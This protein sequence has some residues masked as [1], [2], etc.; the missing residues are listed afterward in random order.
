MPSLWKELNMEDTETLLFSGKD[1]QSKGSS[2]IF[3]SLKK[4]PDLAP[5]VNKLCEFMDKSTIDDLTPL[6]DAVVS[7]SESITNKWKGGNGFPK[8]GVVDDSNIIVDKWR[9]GNG[10]VKPNKE[11]ERRK[12]S[13]SISEKFNKPE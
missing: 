6:E 4:D 13:S 3:K 12:L 1:I 8:G 7:E 5:L 11:D 2:N 10:Y 9:N